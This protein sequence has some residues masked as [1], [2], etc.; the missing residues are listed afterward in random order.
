MLACFEPSSARTTCIVKHVFRCVSAR[1]ARPPGR[2]AVAAAL[3]FGCAANPSATAC[4]SQF[5]ACLR[6]EKVEANLELCLVF[7]PDTWAD[8]RRLV[9]GGGQAGAGQ[10]GFPALE[11]FCRVRGAAAAC[12]AAPACGC[13]A[14]LPYG[15]RPPCPNTRSGPMCTAGSWANHASLVLPAAT[16][17]RC[18]L[19]LRLHAAPSMLRHVHF[20]CGTPSALPAVGCPTSPWLPRVPLRVMAVY[21]SCCLVVRS[22]TPALPCCCCCFAGA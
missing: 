3:T 12:T 4:R 2:P 6:Q 7:G 15:H 11:R 18:L 8:L 10:Q 5:E 9:L 13:W 17:C 19:L 22:P 14:A 21:I 1:N 20:G 16:Q